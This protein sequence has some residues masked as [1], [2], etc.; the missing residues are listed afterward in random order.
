MKYLKL[1]EELDNEFYEK[2]HNTVMA[3]LLMEDGRGKTI[4]LDVNDMISVIRLM[5]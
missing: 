2:I 4:E 5:G 1:Y 3:N